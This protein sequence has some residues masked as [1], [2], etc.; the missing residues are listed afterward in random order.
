MRVLKNFIYNLYGRKLGYIFQDFFICFENL[1]NVFF[2][3]LCL[4]NM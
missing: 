3:L 1:I 2:C 4:S